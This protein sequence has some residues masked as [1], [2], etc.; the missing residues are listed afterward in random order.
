MGGR[1][2]RTSRIYV[3]GGDTLIGA[4]LLERLQAERYEHIAGTPPHEPDLTDAG[5]V[6]DF[7]S[8]A[9]PEY[10][11]M[12]AGNSGGIQAN[13]SY[14]ADLMLHNLLVTV[15]M[16]EAARRHGVSKLL[17]L[18]SSCSY[19]RNARQPLGVEALLGGPLEPTSEAYALAKLAGTRLCQAYREQYGVFFVTAIPAN[20]FGRHDDFSVDNAH[21]VPALIGKMHRAKIRNEGEVTIWGTGVPRREFIY[22]RDLADACL[23]VM[24]N[25]DEPA[26]INLGGGSVL[27]IAE[28]ARAVAEVVGYRGRLRFDSSKPDGAPLKGL[29]SSALSALG[30]RPQTDFRTALEETY[31]WFQDHVVMEDPADVPAAV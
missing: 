30:W 24:A 7:F 27:S 14:P 5:Q 8:E 29:D 9:R 18:G 19:P 6:E 3:A 23:F 12:A 15:N 26:S 28:L 13:R 11:F 25:Y 17:Y 1:V 22:S 21:V 10:V 2:H 20:P 16:V 4:A 31:T